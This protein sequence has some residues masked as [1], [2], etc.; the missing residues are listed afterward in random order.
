MPFSLRLSAAPNHRPGPALSQAKPL[1]H[2][3][4][5]VSCALHRAPDTFVPG[6]LR[7]SAPAFCPWRCLRSP[8]ASCCAW[9]IPSRF[10][11]SA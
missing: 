4:A 6:R 3:P 5:S 9:P 10:C 8:S 2:F 7:A 1:F 11:G